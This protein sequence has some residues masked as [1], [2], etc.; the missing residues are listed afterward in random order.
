MQRNFILK[1]Q[2]NI[3]PIR[4]KFTKFSDLKN[5]TISTA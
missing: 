3:S 1:E 4:N 2:E 5:T